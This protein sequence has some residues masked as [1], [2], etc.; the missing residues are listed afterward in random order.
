MIK[1]GSRRRACRVCKM[2]E[3]EVRFIGLARSICAICQTAK[4]AS[5]PA[6]PP[7][8]KR[9]SRRQ[10]LNPEHL[11]WVRSLPCSTAAPGCT[12]PC[13]AHH[14]RLGTDGGTGIKPSDKWTVP[15]CAA[16]H[17]ELH[18]HG[19]RSFEARYGLDL[20]AVAESLA[21]SSPHQG[22]WIDAPA[23]GG[24]KYRKFWN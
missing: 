4:K 15:L 24:Q 5:R 22:G 6:P 19:A 23:G 16:H 3:P 17:Q 14:V 8:R 11:V 2:G 20:K 18:D 1:S 21:I 13:H 9:T 7:R 12:S 10:R